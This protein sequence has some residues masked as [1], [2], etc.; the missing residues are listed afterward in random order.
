MASTSGGCLGTNCQNIKTASSSIR[1]PGSAAQTTNILPAYI[2]MCDQEPISII[3]KNSG[4]TTIYDV[5]V[6][7]L[8]PSD[9]HYVSGT[10]NPSDPEN[11]SANPLRWTKNQIPGLSQLN[12]S[13]K[14][15]DSLTITFDVSTTCGPP[16]SG[17]ISSQAFFKTPCG[18]I[19]NSQSST[20]NI[21]RRYPDITIAKTGR[22]QAT[23]P[24][25]IEN[26]VA[27]VSDTVIWRVRLANTGN[28]PAEVVYL[29]DVLPPN[30]N[31]QSINPAPLSGSGTSANPWIL[32]PINPSTTIDYNITGQIIS[33][34]VNRNNTATVYWG[35]GDGCTRP[36]TSNSA[37]LRTN[38][39]ISLSQTL[40]N[41]T[42]CGG[43]ISINVTNSGSSP[44]ARNVQVTSVLPTGFVYDYNLSTPGPSPNP[45]VNP[46]Q[47]IW[48]LG[49]FAPGQTK[50]ITFR[51]KD[52][53]TSCDTVITSN[54]TVSATYFNSCGGQLNA[55]PISTS[56]TPYKPNLIVDKSPV[57]QVV[58]VQGQ[59]NWTITVG[60]TGNTNANNVTVI[61]ILDPN[62]NSSTIIASNGF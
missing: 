24:S 18:S 15:G 34:D 35:C 14:P 7:A 31:L 32:P 58:G 54:N 23:Q 2:N 61:D 12:A 41:F 62:W 29:W 51:V 46:S 49:D 17:Q 16:Q 50:N 55:G 5:N 1:I 60:N 9:L 57:I 4:L 13:G 45:P 59:A 36:A 52:N 33:C 20:S 11:I 10:G 3:V 28:A 44:T 19:S 26:V 56:V 21:N 37:S 25:F 6:T 22:N 27:E 43:Q 48:N 40:T 47:S 30:M 39:S 53:G 42:T 8:I 38:P